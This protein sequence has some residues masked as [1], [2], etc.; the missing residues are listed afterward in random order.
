MA[1]Y[2]L[3]PFSFLDLAL[4]GEDLNLKLSDFK[5]SPVLGLAPQWKEQDKKWSIKAYKFFD[6]LKLLSISSYQPIK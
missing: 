6:I 5:E 3:G 4:S 2:I 1:I